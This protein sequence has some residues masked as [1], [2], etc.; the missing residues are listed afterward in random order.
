[1]SDPQPSEPN[2]RVPWWHW[3]NW[4]ALDAVAVVVVWLWMFAGMTGA[5]LTAV[6]S[7]VVGAAVVLHFVTTLAARW[8]PPTHPTYPRPL[9]QRRPPKANSY[10]IW[11]IADHPNQGKYPGQ[12]L[13]FVVIDNYIYIV[14]FE[15][16]DEVIWL[17]TII[18]SRK[19]T[20]RY[21]E[22]Q[23]HETE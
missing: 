9:L 6:N 21:L 11:R 3:I 14:P 4:L 17:V 13:F 5:R 22:D 19:A 18:P 8:Q 7:L 12:R 20:K 23:G 15:M 1:M 10:Q 2:S 16:R